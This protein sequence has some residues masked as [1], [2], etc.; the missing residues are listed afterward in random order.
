MICKIT[1]KDN[2]TNTQGSKHLWGIDKTGALEY[3]HTFSM[4]INIITL[5][6]TFRFRKQTEHMFSIIT[7]SGDYRSTSDRVN[8]DITINYKYN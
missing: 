5:Y 7:V 8:K 1:K 4:E 3:E 6:C 2:K